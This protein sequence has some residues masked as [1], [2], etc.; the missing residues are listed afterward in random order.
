MEIV[1]AP[2]EKGTRGPTSALAIVTFAQIPNQGEQIQKM[3]TS[4]PLSEERTAVQ[5]HLKDT[6]VLTNEDLEPFTCTEVWLG[7]PGKAHDLFVVNAQCH[8][9]VEDPGTFGAR[10]G[11]ATRAPTE[12]A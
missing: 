8:F 1:K 2:P 3:M 6:V 11:S 9:D 10:F 7:S 4:A 12:L 5:S